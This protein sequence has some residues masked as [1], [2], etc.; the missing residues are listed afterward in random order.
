MMPLRGVRGCNGSKPAEA[1]LLAGCGGRPASWG[2]IVVSWSP[3]APTPARPLNSLET[4]S[5]A[6]PG[7]H[8]Q[9]SACGIPNYALELAPRPPHIPRS[10]AQQKLGSRHHHR[11][12]PMPARK[13]TI[14]EIRHPAHAAHLPAPRMVHWLVICWK[15]E[16]ALLL[17]ITLATVAMSVIST[18]LTELCESPR[19]VRGRVVVWACGRGRVMPL[20]ARVVLWLCRLSR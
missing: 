16:F 4:R 18:P 15:R 6:C 10:F 2:G 8:T 12:S 1:L 5:L 19:R 11:A 3:R 17:P 7:A 14:A 20:C 9:S 13:R